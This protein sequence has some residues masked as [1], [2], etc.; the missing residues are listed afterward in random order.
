M[1]KPVHYN[2][3]GRPYRMKATK[4]SLKSLP[5]L[6]QEIASIR[7]NQFENE[8]TRG[9]TEKRGLSFSAYVRLLIDADSVYT[10][11]SD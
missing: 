10:E 11:S 5:D 1:D 2:I 3:N 9:N 6:Q 7:I 8:L 4:P